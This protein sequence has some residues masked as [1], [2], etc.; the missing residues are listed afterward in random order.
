VYGTVRAVVWEDGCSTNGQLP[1]RFKIINEGE[2]YA[3]IFIKKALVNEI[4]NTA[5]AFIKEFDDIQE[6][7]EDLHFDGVDRTPQEMIAYQLGWMDLIRK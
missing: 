1:T 2:K 6:N 3:G 7:E 5:D 4:K